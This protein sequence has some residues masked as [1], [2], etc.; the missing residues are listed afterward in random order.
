HAFVALP[1]LD[2][3]KLLLQAHAVLGLGRRRRL[4][5]GAGEEQRCEPNAALHF[6][7]CSTARLHITVTRCARYSGEACRSLLSPSGLTLMFATA[8]GA[9]FAASAF[10]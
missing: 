5:G 2:P 1:G 10:A 6:R 9:N 7:A 8:S 3:R 4:A